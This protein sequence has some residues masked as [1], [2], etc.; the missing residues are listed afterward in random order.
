MYPK[1]S[2]II[3][4]VALLKARYLELHLNVICGVPHLAPFMMCI[5]FLQYH[6]AP[7]LFTDILSYMNLTFTMCFT[8]ECVLKL[9]AYGPGVRNRLSLAINLSMA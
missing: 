5:L 2:F 3:L 4:K 9:I 7:L 6:G 8:F 1:T